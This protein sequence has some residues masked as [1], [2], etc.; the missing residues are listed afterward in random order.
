MAHERGLHREVQ[1]AK[2]RYEGLCPMTGMVD[3]TDMTANHAG[4]A[5][6]NADA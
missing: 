6:G 4:A 2:C 5:T 1:L 3:V